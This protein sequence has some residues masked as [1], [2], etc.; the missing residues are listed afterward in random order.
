MSHNNH[1]NAPSMVL[2]STYVNSLLYCT[3]PP[4]L[5]VFLTL[6]DFFGIKLA[7]WKSHQDNR[8]CESFDSSL[9]DWLVL[10]VRLPVITSPQLGSFRKRHAMHSPFIQDWLVHTHSPD[11]IVTQ[12]TIRTFNRIWSKHDRILL[13]LLVAHHKGRPQRWFGLS[14]RRL[15]GNNLLWEQCQACC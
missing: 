1:N 8:A 10:Q 5:T 11:T 13:L 4:V 7:D 2:V 9:M 3:F 12:S 6:F 15:H 14:E